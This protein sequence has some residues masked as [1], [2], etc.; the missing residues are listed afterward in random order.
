LVQNVPLIIPTRHADA[1]ITYDATGEYAGTFRWSQK[2]D[3][4]QM[5]PYVA[6]SS[7]G[8]SWQDFFETRFNQ[9]DM[10]GNAKVVLNVPMIDGEFH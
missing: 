7:I 3:F 6:P 1:V 2:K 9:E 10:D 4:V 5:P 8:G